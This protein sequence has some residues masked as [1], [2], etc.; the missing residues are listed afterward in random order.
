ML[1]Q[2]SKGME[3]SFSSLRYCLVE[4][5]RDGVVVLAQDSDITGPRLTVDSIRYDFGE[6]SEGD[7]VE[8][9][10]VFTNTGDDTLEIANVYT[11]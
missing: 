9:V 6:I 8:H 11:G 7:V 5:Y 2:K 1:Y 3:N 10:F 4:Q